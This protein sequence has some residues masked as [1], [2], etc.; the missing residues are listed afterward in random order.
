MKIT[1]LFLVGIIALITGCVSTTHMTTPDVITPADVQTLLANDSTTVILD[2]RSSFEF[3][4]EYGHL[5]GAILIPVTELEQRIGEL[6][7][8]K[9]QHIITVCQSG[10]R[11]LRAVSMLHAQGFIATS[12]TGGMSRWNAEGFPVE[13]S[14]R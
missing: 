11:S 1:I 8:Y 2:V 13:K 10:S 14:K 6:A 5:K 12:M 7:K 4:D 9:S 3:A